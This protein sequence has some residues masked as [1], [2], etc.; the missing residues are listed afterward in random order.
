MSI[1]ILEPMSSQLCP[2]ARQT[3][4][5][6]VSIVALICIHST[7]L[8]LFSF[9]MPPHSKDSKGAEVAIR[10]S[11]FQQSRGEKGGATIMFGHF[12]VC[13]GGA[14]A[15][16]TGREGRRSPTVLSADALCMRSGRC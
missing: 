3:A 6:E 16:L 1:R 2:D 7:F 5:M 9:L 14:V 15:T 8:P 13:F 12:L 11:L 10:S 4:G